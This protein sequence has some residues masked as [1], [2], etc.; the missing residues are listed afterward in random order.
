[1]RRLAADAVL[2]AAAIVFIETQRLSLPKDNLF[3]AVNTIQRGLQL[4]FQGACLHTLLVRH[5]K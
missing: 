3:G 2:L 5:K 1:M 4:L